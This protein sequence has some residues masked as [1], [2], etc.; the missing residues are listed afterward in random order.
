[1]NA[2]FQLVPEHLEWSTY[3]G[4]TQL[5]LLLYI[6]YFWESYFSFILW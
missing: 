4:K 3:T 2:Q 6:G 5:L 1:V